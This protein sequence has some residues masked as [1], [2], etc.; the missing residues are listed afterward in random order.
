MV[1]KRNFK[2]KV[3]R[4]NNGN[5]KVKVNTKADAKRKVE[6]VSGML[7][8]PFEYNMPLAMANDYLA[9]R[10]AHGTPQEKRMSKYQYLCYCV[11]EFHGLLG[12]CVKVHVI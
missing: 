9:D 6:A 8:R 4:T 5:D 12:T 10:K 7:I 11:N 3:K 1:E 2:G